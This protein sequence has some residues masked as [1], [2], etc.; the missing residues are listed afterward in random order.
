MVQIYLK[1]KNNHL[2]TN[3]YSLQEE[4]DIYDACINE[5]LENTRHIL[6]NLDYLVE[7]R[8]SWKNYRGKTPTLPLNHVEKAKHL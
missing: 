3:G 2:K 8:V 4:S 5:V 1:A 6:D 7:F